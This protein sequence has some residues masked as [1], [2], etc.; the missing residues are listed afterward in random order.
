MLNIEKWKTELLEFSDIAVVGGIPQNCDI[1][2]CTDCDFCKSE[3]CH[4]S[5]I[6]WL[7]SEYVRPELLLPEDTPKDTAVLV[8]DDKQTWYKEH[9][10]YVS[11][12]ACYCYLEGKTSWSVENEHSVRPWR[13]AKLAEEGI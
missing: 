2:T 10:A 4:K 5:F 9:L 11:N 12:S 7:S 3:D 6:K 8:S 1:V 13:Y